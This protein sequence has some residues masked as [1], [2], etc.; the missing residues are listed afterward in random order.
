MT[1]SG[2][3]YL[4]TLLCPATKAIPLKE[5]SSPEI[6]HGLLS[7]FSRMGFPAELQSDQGSV[8]TSALTT[9]FLE[10][11][12]IKV[13]HSSINHPQTNSVER[14]HSVLKQVLKTLCKE[15][16][17]HWV[18]CLPAAMFALRTVLHELTGFSPAEFVYGRELRSPF[19]MLREI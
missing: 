2:H 9:T 12:G 13:I 17:R 19:R 8:F 6:V 14:W 3:K 7:I 15:N 10:R 18:R 16:S 4:L 1:S 5:L 11:C